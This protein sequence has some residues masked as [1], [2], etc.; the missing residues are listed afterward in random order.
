[1]SLGSILLNHVTIRHM[2]L[3]EMWSHV[4]RPLSLQHNAYRLEMINAC[5]E[6]DERR[7]G[8]K[9]PGHARLVLK[10]CIRFCNNNV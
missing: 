3:R 6:K 1:M 9:Q 8:K 5:S 7:A 10:L 4:A 2:I